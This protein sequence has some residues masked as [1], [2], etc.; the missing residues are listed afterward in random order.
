MGGVI[1][2]ESMSCVL[3]VFWANPKNCSFYVR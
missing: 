3:D 2:S 1:C